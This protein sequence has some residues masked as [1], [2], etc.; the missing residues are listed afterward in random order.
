MGAK[1]KHIYV[2]GLRG[3]STSD[4]ISLCK[5]LKGSGNTGISLRTFNYWVEGD[6]AKL[7]LTLHNINA[8]KASLNLPETEVIT[9]LLETATR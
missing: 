8:I 9:E 4:K 5:C 3:L 7:P 1:L 2:L 6:A